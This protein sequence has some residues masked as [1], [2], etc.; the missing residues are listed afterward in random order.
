[1]HLAPHPNRNH[2]VDRRMLLIAG[3]AIPVGILGTLAAW[4]LK[5]LQAHHH[6]DRR[7][8]MRAWRRRS[9]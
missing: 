8:R 5:P 7:E 2:A 9:R 4:R 6:D 1:M 3:Q